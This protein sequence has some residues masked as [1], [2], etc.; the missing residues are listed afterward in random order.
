M[1]LMHCPLNGPRN[2]SE[3]QYGGVVKTMPD[4]VAGSDDAWRD[5][6]VY[7]PNV[8]G[9]VLEW[10][11]HLPTSYWFIAERDTVSDRIIRTMPA[12]EMFGATPAAGDE[13]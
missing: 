4:P 8:A 13:T 11:C 12:A 3:F 9:P 5:Y 7:E 1:K 10:W 2:I 6:I